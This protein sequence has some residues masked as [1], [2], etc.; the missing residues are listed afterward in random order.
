MKPNYKKGIGLGITFFVVFWLT[1]D[2][3]ALGI[4]LGVAMGAALSS[5]PDSEKNNENSVS[6]NET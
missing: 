6:D 5:T 3:F 2:N 1:L 4:G